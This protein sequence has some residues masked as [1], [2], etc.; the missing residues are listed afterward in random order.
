VADGL[1]DATVDGVHVIDVG[2]P[3]GRIDRI[4]NATRRVRDRAL[5]LRTDICHIHDPELLLAA[6][7][8]SK[9]GLCVCFDSHEDVPRQLLSKHYLPTPARRPV[10]FLWKSLVEDPMCSRLDGVIA[11][12][13]GI[14]RRF[15]GVARRLTVVRNYPLLSE[16]QPAPTERPPGNTLCYLGAIA[17]TR[18][19]LEAIDALAL[20]RTPPTLVI[21]GS[22]WEPGFWE[23]A[24]RSAGFAHVKHLGVVDRAEVASVLARA[25]AG[26]VTLHPTPNHIESIPVKMFEYMAAGL[27]IIASDFRLWRD[28]IEE[29]QC[30]LAVDPLDPGAIARAIDTLMQDPI[31]ARAMGQRGRRAIETQLNWDAE[32]VALLQFYDELRATRAR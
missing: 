14:R 12:T 13:P 7:Q 20:T 27:P 6:R 5:T 9:S 17:S 19:V 15:A 21:A 2:A 25:C 11:A 16:F 28:I 1:G 30:G 4:L 22:C 32:A 3:R 23:K 29:H 31:A 8:L 24:R 10:A 18:G 26:L